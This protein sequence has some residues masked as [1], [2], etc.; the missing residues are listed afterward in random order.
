MKFWKNNSTSKIKLK[1]VEPE[2]LS[3][4]KVT[5]QMGN[6]RITNYLD[7]LIIR[8]SG[9]YGVGSLGNE[10]AQY[11]YAKGEFGINSYEP[12]GIIIDLQKIE[13]EWGNTMDLVLTI[14][15]K[16]NEDSSSPIA[17]VIGDK[18][19]EALGTLVH[20]IENNEPATT[21]ENI[22]DDFI[23]AWEYIE[24]KMEEPEL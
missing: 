21:R 24:K 14:G 4:I 22:F 19:K 1:V 6:S 8:F 12:S 7:V 11:M 20:G 3:D 13:Y 10:D 9:K 18:C 2:N 16:Q 23:E 15:L 17:F 5:Y